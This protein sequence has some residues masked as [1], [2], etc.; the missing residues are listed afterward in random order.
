MK[1]GKAKKRSMVEQNSAPN[2]L[3]AEKKFHKFG[4]MN[5]E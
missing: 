2:E 1:L 5:T 4:R 3:I